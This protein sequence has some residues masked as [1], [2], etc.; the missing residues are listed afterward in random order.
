MQFQKWAEAV[1]D[2]RLDQVELV[3]RIVDLEESQQLNREYRGMDK[4]TNVL[5]FPFEAPEVVE[6]D[7]IGDLVICAPV[8]AAEAAEQ[9]KPLEAHWAHLVV[10]GVLHLLGFDHINDQQAEEMENLE[11]EI[12]ANLGFSNPY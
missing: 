11:V 12:L 2:N 4:P 10:H 1:L 6:S 9:G 3:I 5:S 8:V 7:H